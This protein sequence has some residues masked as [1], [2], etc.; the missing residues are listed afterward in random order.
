VTNVRTGKALGQGA[1]FSDTLL[2]YEA[3]IYRVE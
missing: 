2:P 3:N 1:T